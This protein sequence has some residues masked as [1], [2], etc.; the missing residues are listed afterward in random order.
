MPLVS[1]P[2]V[3]ALIVCLLAAGCKPDSPAR[4]IAGGPT[5]TSSV[6]SLTPPAP[7]GPAVTLK[8][9]PYAASLPQVALN[10]EL[11]YRERWLRVRQTVD[12]TNASPDDWSEVVL[13]VPIH[14]QPDAF[15]L[16]SVRVTLGADV[17]DGTPSFFGQETMLHIP[18]LRPARP[19][20]AIKVE[21]GYRVILPPILSTDW[22]P[23]G[24]TGWI[25]DIVQAGEWYPAL[26]PYQD[27]V[28]WHTW[29]YHPVGDPTVYPLTDTSL[30][31]TTDDSRVVVASGGLV[32]HTDATWRFH[33]HAARGIAFLA[34]DQ[35][36]VSQRDLD[37][38]ALTSVYRSTDAIA[39]KAAL[40][41]AERAIRLYAEL[42][43]PY[44]YDSLTIAENGFF[45]GM[46]Y[47][48]LVSITDYG[49]TTFKNQP[50]S[51]LHV[52][53][54]HETAHQWWYGAVGN[55]QTTEPWLDESLAFYSEFLYIERYYPD[56]KDWWW[57]NRV[58]VFEPYGPVDATIYSYEKS[59][60]FIPSM[61]GQAARFVRDL[62]QLMGDD[63]FFAFLKD[64]YQSHR[65]QFVTGKDFLDTARRHSKV[66]LEP[67]IKAY[68]ANPN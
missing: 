30:T 48:E 53:V 15:Q 39:G 8:A 22:P 2:L 65:W 17:Q 34:S 32:D 29:T 59:E 44:P 33:V 24:N 58:D 31:V 41:I 66:D 38:I 13:D 45:A 6:D 9:P 14:Y 21:L 55:D 52:L 5:Q 19:G 57:K 11:F 43:G 68:F 37:G 47:S 12:L 23:Q 61:Y 60:Y 62:R 42:Y 20:E 18:L 64:Y 63:D 10:V 46:E 51:V 1:R 28:G 25:D 4:S 3:P 56:L 50:D 49:Y 67:L 7:T 26:V 27:G 36:Q 35:Y 40:D 16:D 54:A